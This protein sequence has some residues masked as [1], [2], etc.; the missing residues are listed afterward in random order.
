M[1]RPDSKKKSW[2]DST[3]QAATMEK[4]QIKIMLNTRK[5]KN[6]M[7]NSCQIRVPFSNCRDYSCTYALQIFLLYP[8]FF[9]V[10]TKRN[11][12]CEIKLSLTFYQLPVRISKMKRTQK[13]QLGKL[14]NESFNF[15]ISRSNFAKTTTILRIILFDCRSHALR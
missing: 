14:H 13:R 8:N 5:N 3:R 6:I 10:K 7:L 1:T 4:E 2:V 9:N 15:Q 11:V 12:I